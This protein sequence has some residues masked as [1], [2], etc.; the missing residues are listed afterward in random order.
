MN[1]NLIYK[2]AITRIPNVGN[3]IAKNLISHCG[4]AEAV[5]K[6]SK[7]QLSKISRIGP[8]IIHNIVKANVEELAKNDLEHLEKYPDVKPL[9]YTDKNFPQRL[10]NY[11][12]TPL[13]LYVKGSADLNLLRT[14]AIIGTRKATE[15]GKILCEKLVEGLKFYGASVVSGLAYGIDGCAH[16]KSVQLNI[17]NIAVLGS[18]I[19]IIYPS[20]HR[21]LARSIEQNG[22]LISQFP[23]GAQPDRENFPI[24][25]HVVAGISD[26]VVVVQSQRSGG[27]II[28]AEI[29]NNFNKDVFAF[30]G[31]IG[32]P[33]SDGCNALIKQ[34]KAHLIESAKDIAY[35]MRWEAQERIEEQMKLFEELP[36]KLKEVMNAMIDTDTLDIDTLHGKLKRPLSQLSSDLLAL[37]FKG[38][39]KSLP[40]KRYMRI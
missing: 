27:S 14:V 34:H 3:V 1:Q 6:S 35:I 12:V 32:D 29:A 9:F 8:G 11:E 28:T 25:N 33:K 4:S 36:T 23:F 13:L 16:R 22:A 20:S 7:K 26:A 38:L 15:Y 2:I 31:R 40:G 21:D 17:S 24:R 5:F 39:I 37:E 19:D 18:G 30:P 10:R